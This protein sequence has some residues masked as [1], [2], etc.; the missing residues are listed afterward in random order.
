MT[1]A[2]GVAI[3]TGAS[4]GIGRAI[5]AGLA[6]TGYRIVLSYRDRAQQA[7]DLVTKIRAA[8]GEAVPVRAD[9]G[10]PAEADALV[11]AALDA[12]GH[13][14]VLVNNAGVHLPGVPLVAVRWEEWE[15]LLRVNLSG[16]LRLIQAVIPHMRERKRGHIVNISS[17]VSQRLPA[18]NGPYT[19]SK[20]GL[21]ALTRILAKEEGPH[22]IRVNAIAPGPIRTDM[23]EESLEVMGSERAEAFIRSVPLGRTGQP[24]EIASVVAFL[25]SD[26]ASYIT[27]QVIYVNGGGPGG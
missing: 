26:A 6:A 22:G 17:N 20:V 15:R 2:A 5:A 19:V 24:E 18:G 27:G 1:R 11:R 3:V 25:V 4:R 7:N 21:E 8:G 23:L 9:V 14:D 12:F 16:P 13:V 10:Q